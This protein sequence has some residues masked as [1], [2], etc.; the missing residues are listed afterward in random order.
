M[1]PRALTPVVVDGNANDEIWKT[2]A[3]Y[4]YC[5]PVANVEKDELTSCTPKM[6]AEVQFAYDK[7]Y[8][9]VLAKFTDDDVLQYGE[10][11]FEHLYKTGDVLELFLMSVKSEHYWEIYGTPNALHS[12]MFFP[13]KGRVIFPFAIK[14]D[15]VVLV[16]STV[17][18]T[19]NHWQ[20]R[21]KGAVIEMAVS[22][23]DLTKYGDEIG[24]GTQWKLLAA[25]YN[26]SVT[27]SEGV[28]LSTFPQLPVA[29]YHNRDGYINIEFA[30]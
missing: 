6:P 19:L 28:E 30:K 22:M 11:N 17:N 3:S 16:T 27:L 4:S 9:Y 12:L 2:T 25:R 13:N 18:G 8:F 1:I 7:D 29:N 14:K 10:E 26:Y 5:L 23:K 20:D 15:S 24:P 21:D